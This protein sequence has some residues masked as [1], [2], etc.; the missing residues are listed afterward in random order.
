MWVTGVLS[1]EEVKAILDSP[2]W[3]SK[4]SSIVCWL[5]PQLYAYLD[6]HLDRISGHGNLKKE[7]DW[8]VIE[9]SKLTQLNNSGTRLE[10][11]ADTMQ[12]SLGFIGVQDMDNKWLIL[13]FVKLIWSINHWDENAELNHIDNHTWFGMSILSSWMPK[14]NGFPILTVGMLWLLT[15]GNML[16]SFLCTC[17]PC[18]SFGE[19][20]FLHL[21]PFIS[22]CWCLSCMWHLNWSHL[23]V[24]NNVIYV[25]QLSSNWFMQT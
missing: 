5:L 22:L 13:L 10:W 25:C 14:C 24:K 18:F 4:F 11:K 12:C 1:K 7:E 21:K 19:V 6:Y 23:T 17:Y 16:G 20:M 2:V 3:Y 15:R 9:I 8:A